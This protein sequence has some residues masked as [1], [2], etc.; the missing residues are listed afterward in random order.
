MS[1]DVDVT[2]AGAQLEIGIT[3]TVPA[4]QKFFHRIVVITEGEVVRII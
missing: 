4:I 2:I 3:L 1:K